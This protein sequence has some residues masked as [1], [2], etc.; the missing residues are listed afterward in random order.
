MFQFGTYLKASITSNP[1]DFFVILFVHQLGGLVKN[2]GLLEFGIYLVKLFMGQINIQNPYLD[3][4]LVKDMFIRGY[5]DYI[6]EVLASI[7]LLIVVP[8]E[9]L[10]VNG[11]LWSGYECLVTCKWNDELKQMNNI[12]SIIITLIAGVIFRSIFL[13]IERNLLKRAY[14]IALLV[15]EDGDIRNRLVEL[16]FR[17]TFIKIFN[18]EELYLFSI[19]YVVFENYLSFGVW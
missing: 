17:R 18:G 19:L 4:C 7:F 10:T 14:Q 2:S 6:T 13:I 1:L 15:H 8:I 5:L 9:I 12:V 3:D 11:Y 16:S